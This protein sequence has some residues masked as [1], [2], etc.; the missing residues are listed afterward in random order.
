MIYNKDLFDELEKLGWPASPPLING[1]T[2]EYR[3]HHP[4]HRMCVQPIERKGPNAFNRNPTTIRIDD[5]TRCTMVC[6]HS[7]ATGS[8]K[9]KPIRIDM[10][11]RHW[12]KHLISAY[13]V[14]VMSLQQVNDIHA[15]RDERIR[16]MQQKKKDEITAFCAPAGVEASEFA[17]VFKTSFKD[18]QSWTQSEECSIT[19]YIG[20]NLSNS[21][22]KSALLFKH[23][24][25]NGW[26]RQVDFTNSTT[27]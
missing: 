19:S 18:H 24:K 4:T 12:R 10:A 20:Y 3:W 9:V 5:G 16:Y 8:H 26:L 13:T 6:T 7:D 2:K 23:L 14:M 27:Y 1:N 11:K 25:E 21:R 17:K 22:E 15:E